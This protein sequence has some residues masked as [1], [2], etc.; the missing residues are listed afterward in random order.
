VTTRRRGPT[1]PRKTQQTKADQWRRA[2]EWAALVL[3]VALYVVQ[4]AMTVAGNHDG[5]N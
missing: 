1:G 4:L 2:G 5:P 3:R